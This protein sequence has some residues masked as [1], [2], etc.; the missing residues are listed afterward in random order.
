MKNAFT[1]IELLVVVLIVGILAAIALPQY[2]TAV[3]KSRFAVV[4]PLVRAL[5]DAQER[6][7]LANGSYTTEFNKLDI[8]IP[9]GGT[10]SNQTNSDGYSEVMTYPDFRITLNG[11][12]CYASLNVPSVAYL[13]WYEQFAMSDQKHRCYAYYNRPRAVRLCE[14]MG[15]VATSEAW[16]DGTVVY[17]LP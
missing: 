11:K 13:V 6:Y 5:K 12:I 3:D 7:Y 17:N 1:L 14:S 16:E 10:L 4:R 8:E 2:T 15:G 9:G